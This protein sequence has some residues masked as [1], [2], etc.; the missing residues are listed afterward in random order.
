MAFLDDMLKEN[1]AQTVNGC[2]DCGSCNLCTTQDREITKH[3]RCTGC[4]ACMDV[5][6][7]HIIIMMETEDGFA[8]PKVE[9]TK[10]DNCRKCN[11]ICPAENAPMTHGVLEAYAVK[12]S[13]FPLLAHE[14]IKEDG[15]VFAPVY[16]G[17]KRVSHKKLTRED[18]IDLACGTKYVQSSLRYTFSMLRGE[19]ENGHKTFFVGTECQAAGLKNV[20]PKEDDNLLTA[21]VVC[22]GVPSPLA[23][24]RYLQYRRQEDGEDRIADD[25][26]FQWK[27]QKAS[28]EM[29]YHDGK[30]YQGT[31]DTD[32]FLQAAE[33]G[34]IMR[35]SC[36]ECMNK[37]L[38]RSSDL[39]LGNGYV[40]IH[41]KQG[42][43]YWNRI[44]DSVAHEPLAVDTLNGDRALMESIPKNKQSESVMTLMRGTDFK[45]AVSVL[46]KGRGRKR[47]FFGR[48]KR[49]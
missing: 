17:F 20:I 2:A 9:N 27:D 14:I 40:L 26:T 10:C 39:T 42:Q 19:L 16:D 28:I 49:A 13:I 8:Y 44:A 12:K 7:Q 47:S 24:D 5:C 34:L 41:T 31:S 21:D 22:D 33:K 15:S 32:L 45:T 1:N 25:V 3:D 23:W 38:N 46:S 29:T 48:K 6:P 43:A 11:F 18:E 36:T 37:G 4:T 30:T 35:P